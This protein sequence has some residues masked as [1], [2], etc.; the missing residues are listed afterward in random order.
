MKVLVAGATGETGRRVVQTL[1]DKQISVRAMVRDIDKAKEILPEGIEL[2]E[3]DLQKKST[4]DAAIADCDYVISAA[5]SRPSLN[6]AGFYQVD[7]VGTKNLVDAAEAKSVKQFI[8]VT[9]LCVSKFFHPLN[10]F[11]LVLFWKKQAEA[12]LIGSSLKHTI[13]RPG[14]LNTEAIASVVLSGA[15]TVFEGRIPRQLVAEICVA[16]L[17]DA[18]TFDQIIEAVTDEAAPEKPYSEL[19]EAIA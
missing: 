15:D 2:I 12:Y 10:L 9:S 14:G 19:F 17:D 1:L 16:A 11:G 8:L 6:I 13:V 3:A 18:N 7:Y 5:A 4:L